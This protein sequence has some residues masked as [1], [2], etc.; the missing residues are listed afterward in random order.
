M[1]DAPDHGLAA[2]GH[3]DAAVGRADVGLHRVDRQ[4]ALVGDL[5]VAQPQG[6]QPQDLGLARGEPDVLAEHG[7]GTRGIV[8]VPV[9]V[10]LAIAGDGRADHLEDLVD[11]TGQRHA[12]VD[13][14][15]HR[16]GGQVGAQVA[17]QGHDRG[18]V[19]LDEAVEVV[20]FAVVQP[21]DVVED[22]V[23]LLVAGGGRVERDHLDR[24]RA[25]GEH[26]DESGVHD[27]VRADDRRGDRALRHGGTFAHPGV[28]PARNGRRRRMRRR[29][30]CWSIEA[31]QTPAAIRV[32]PVVWPGTAPGSA[33]PGRPVGRRRCRS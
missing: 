12:G 31:A 25:R 19:V 13:A 23:G 28:G 22:D 3:P 16:A 17:G 1:L 27:L 2:A 32:R 15:R 10:G 29:P 4:E 8:A 21:E 9:H 6:Q 26:A 20:A 7:V 30:G 11:V 24:A 5:L 14:L 33:R 18:V